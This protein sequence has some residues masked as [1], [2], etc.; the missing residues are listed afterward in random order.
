ML[1]QNHD[2]NIEWTEKKKLYHQMESQP[3]PV[4]RLK[5]PEEKKKKKIFLTF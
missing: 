4:H 1:Y 3:S 2:Y 5:L